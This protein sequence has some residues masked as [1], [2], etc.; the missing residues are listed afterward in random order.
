MTKNMTLDNNTRKELANYGIQLL[1]N[2]LYLTN[3]D[4]LNKLEDNDRYYNWYHG[5]TQIYLPRYFN[6][7]KAQ[8][9]YDLTTYATSG[10]VST[11]YFGDKFSSEKMELRMF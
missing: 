2:H 1:Q 6:S 11:Q 9:N 4:H 7:D 5:Y 8:N 10:I 3:M